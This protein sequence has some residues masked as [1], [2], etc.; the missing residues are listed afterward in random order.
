MK[1]NT[2]SWFEIATDDPE[3]VQHFYAELFGWKF[4]PDEAAAQGGMDYR[5]ITVDGGEP[6]G[7]VWA[8]GGRIPNHSVFS[9]IVRDVAQTLARVEELGG[10]VVHSVIG[11]ENGPDF[12]YV[13]DP[14][15][16]LFGIASAPQED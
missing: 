6:C 7:G 10:K 4:T 14:S 8:T 9:V 5:V 3:P 1:T 12:A 15:A 11:N 16:G 13:L 2:V